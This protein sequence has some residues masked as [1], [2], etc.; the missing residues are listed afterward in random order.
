MSKDSAISPR[1]FFGRLYHGETSFDFVGKSKIGFTISIILILLTLGSFFTRGLNLGIDFK[2][3]VAWQVPSSETMDVDTA[4][5][6]LE[7]N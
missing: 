6:V 4:R 5:A 7:D 1:G 3:G 2:G